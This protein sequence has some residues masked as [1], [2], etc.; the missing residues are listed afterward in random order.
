ME[1]NRPAALDTVTFPDSWHVFMTAQGLTDRS[2]EV[3]LYSRVA[4]AGT[5]EQWDATHEALTVLAAGQSGRVR[6]S[7]R[8]A[9]KRITTTAQMAEWK[10]ASE[11]L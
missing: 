6:A 10:A 9:M 5:Q 2:L 11:A 3:G 7:T 8:A 4:F 1:T